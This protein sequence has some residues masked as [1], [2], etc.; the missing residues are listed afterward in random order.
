MF[1]VLGAF[2]GQLGR[3]G[4]KLDVREAPLRKE[5]RHD[6]VDVPIGLEATLL[7]SP[8]EERRDGE[9]APLPKDARQQGPM[10]KVEKTKVG[11]DWTLRS[12]V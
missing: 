5:A 1:T 7:S 6:H 9:G 2:L 3:D 10:T 4:G 11:Y 8:R 12:S